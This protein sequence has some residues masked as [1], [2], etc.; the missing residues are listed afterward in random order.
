MSAVLA[1]LA[2]MGLALPPR[3]VVVD[4]ASPFLLSL[5]GNAVGAHARSSVGVSQLPFNISV[6]VEMIVEVA[7]P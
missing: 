2:E 6:E 1:R 4:E 3:Q 5:F 7:G